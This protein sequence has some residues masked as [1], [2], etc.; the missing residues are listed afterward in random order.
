ML[1]AA[2]AAPRPERSAVVA[3][4]ALTGAVAAFQLALAAGAPWGAA[5]WGGAQPG[6]LPRRLR[7][8]SA[9]SAAGYGLLAA[10][11]ASTLVP[12]RARRRVLTAASGLTAVGTL[13]NLASPSLLERLLW[14]PVAAA[15]TVLLARSRGPRPR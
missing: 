6:V 2:V 1:P 8:A 3:A 13:L 10:T 5:A 4:T 15:L 7:A 9:A 12:A 14:T 11:T